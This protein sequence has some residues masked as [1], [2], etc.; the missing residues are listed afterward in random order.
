ML[1]DDVASVVLDAL[2]TAVA[3]LDPHGTVLTLN[4]A[5]RHGAATGIAL[6]PVRPGG[7]WLAACAAAGTSAHLPHLEQLATM[8][9][10]LLDNPRSPSH[11]EIHYPG[12]HGPRWLYVQLRPLVGG[13]GLVVLVDDVTK[14]HDL[15]DELRHH[16]TH[17]ALTG[18]ANRL[19][20]TQ[21]LAELWRGATGTAREQTAEQT[22]GQATARDADRATSGDGI[23]PAALFF[24][25]LD[26]FRNINNAF[27]YRI[28]DMVLRT[29]AAR[30]TSAL[31][32]TDLL[33]R[34]GGDEFVVVAGHLT[35]T[36]AAALAEALTR[37]LTEPL[38]VD[39]HQIRMSASVGMAMLSA[40]TG[41]GGHQRPGRSSSGEPPSPDAV[42]LVQLASEALVRSRLQHRRRPRPLPRP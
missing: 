37:S 15:E 4:Q 39:G 38:A 30:L 11:M 25:D 8:T 34:W 16:A 24:L 41:S 6:V 12:P 26:S 19:P 33:A 27:G 13:R 40:A 18:L 7:C 32:P 20:V 35:S 17:D 2:P 9:R 10:Q 29:T 42:E 21:R 22:A 28:G 36:D 1:T 31:R 3:V 14:R 23:H 5:W